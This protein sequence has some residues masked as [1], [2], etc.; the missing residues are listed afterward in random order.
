MFPLQTKYRW[1]D[2]EGKFGAVRKY[3]VHTGVDLYCESG[4]AVHAVE[5]GIVVNIEN[6]TGPLAGSSWWNDTKSVLIEGKYGV[7]CYGEIEPTV[8]I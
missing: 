1:P 6:F 5:D 7:V 8:Q 4:S 2:K 3:D